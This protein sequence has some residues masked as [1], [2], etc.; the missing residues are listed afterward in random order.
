MKEIKQLRERDFTTEIMLISC[1]MWFNRVFKEDGRDGT[2]TKLEA[3]GDK[4]LL[5]EAGIENLYK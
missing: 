3:Y 4:P 1:Y 2:R 5:Q